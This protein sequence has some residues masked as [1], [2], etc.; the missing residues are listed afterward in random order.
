MGSMYSNRQEC[1]ILL[2]GKGGQ[3]WET[4]L[5]Y[6]T[7]IWTPWFFHVLL[8]HHECLSYSPLYLPEPHIN[9]FTVICQFLPAWL[10]AISILHI[11]SLYAFSLSFF[12]PIVLV[13]WFIEG[14]K[15]NNSWLSPLCGFNGG[16]LAAIVFL[17]F[18]IDLIVHM[19]E[20]LLK[21]PPPPL[22][23]CLSHCEC[24]HFSA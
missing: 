10:S 16:S 14:K 9:A 15:R 13:H 21:W 4:V 23:L 18:V 22:S 8:F 3:I 7:M 20:W 2:Q 17:P 19:L 1:I 5:Q 12:G 24:H 11:N 6:A